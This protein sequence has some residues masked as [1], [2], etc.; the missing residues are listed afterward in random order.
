MTNVNCGFAVRNSGK[1]CKAG[2][3]NVRLEFTIPRLKVKTE[4]WKS[5]F[6]SSNRS[7]KP[8]IGIPGL[9]LKAVTR[10]S[11]FPSWNRKRKPGIHFSMGFRF[12]I[13]AANQKTGFSELKLGK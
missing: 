6:Q 2:I 11:D 1:R 7:S 5:L 10:N 8:G 4:A 13:A 12:G 9:G 3:E